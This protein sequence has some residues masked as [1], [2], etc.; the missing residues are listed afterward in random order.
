MEPT[1]NTKSDESSTFWS[2]ISTLWCCCFSTWTKDSTGGIWSHFIWTPTLVSTHVQ[3][4][5]N[6]RTMGEEHST[7]KWKNHT[8]IYLFSQD[9]PSP[10]S[11]ILDC[12]QVLKSHPIHE[13]DPIP[14]TGR[15]ISKKN[16]K[17]AGTIWN[18]VDP[19]SSTKSDGS[20]TF[21]SGISTL[22]CCCFSTW[23]KDSTGG[24]WSHFI[25]A[26][27]LVSTH[28]QGNFN[29]R[30]MGEEDSTNKWKEHRN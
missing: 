3:G 27:T 13:E 21:C 15:C 19:I 8:E 17:P 12:P 30:T 2:D 23:P 26:P 5:F 4:D 6:P 25:C 16:P 29:P 1:S 24:I 7:N 18:H 28:V 11:T 10:K 20:S 9:G 22:W 14:N